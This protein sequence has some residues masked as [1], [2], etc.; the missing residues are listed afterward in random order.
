MA[1][2]CASP[3]N[4]GRMRNVAAI[5]DRSTIHLLSGTP[6]LAACH[7]AIRQSERTHL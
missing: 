2:Q 3:G 7:S 1:Y 5:I 6:Q 4:T